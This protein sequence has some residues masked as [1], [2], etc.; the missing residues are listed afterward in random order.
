MLFFLQLN[1][2]ELAEGP[3][4]GSEIIFSHR[5]VDIAD[6]KAVVR[7]AVGLRGTFRA[8]LAILLCFGELGNDRNAAQF[9]AGEVNCLLNGC[10]IFELNVTD[11]VRMFCQQSS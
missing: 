4:D 1:E 9:L 8:G 11:T 7:D 3:E 6:V 10:F 2:F 5:E